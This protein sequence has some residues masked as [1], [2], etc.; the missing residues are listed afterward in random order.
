M[1]GQYKEIHTIEIAKKFYD[2]CVKKFEKHKHVHCHLGNS[3]KILQKIL[4]NINE[5]VTFWLDAHSAGEPQPEDTMIPLLQEL[6]VIKNHPIKS[7]LIM[8][9]D[10]R[11]F[12]YYGTSK[13]N[14]EEILK[15][16]NSE[17]VIE[18]FPGHI[19]GDVA[20]ARIR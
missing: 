5:P 16:I 7:H 13:E 2:L 9:D 1:K 20:V 11:L 18:Y 15:S 12:Q 17:Y 6:E 3:P 10:V 14:V 8:I 19:D 4:A